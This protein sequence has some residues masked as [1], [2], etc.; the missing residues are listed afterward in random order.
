MQLTIPQRKDPL[1]RF[2]LL[3]MFAS[4]CYMAV[5]SIT[6]TV[7]PAQA[8]G[9][10]IINGTP[11]PTP[12]L[13]TSD[14]AL[15]FAVATPTPQ[16]W[17]DTALGNASAAA[18]QFA[19]DQ[20]AQLAAEQAAAQAQAE[21]DAAAQA[22][23]DQYLA[24]VGAQAKHSPR[25]DVQA[26]PAFQSG[27]VA[28][29]NGIVIIDNPSAAATAVPLPGY[30]QVVPTISDEQKAVLAERDSNSCPPGEIFYPRAGCHTPGSSGPQPGPVGAP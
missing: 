5:M 12:P 16:G 20:Q 26:T 28:A 25:G 23:H 27:P 14:P 6:A 3:A 8:Q 9:V 19:A 7:E 11:Q 15:V 21:A 29:P 1:A 17:L 18:D 4:V 13:P 2:I 10:I 30:A 22:A 24:N